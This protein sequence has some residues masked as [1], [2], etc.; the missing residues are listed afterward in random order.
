MDEKSQTSQKMVKLTV[1][2][3]QENNTMEI[4]K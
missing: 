1:Y 4:L 3:A 2:L